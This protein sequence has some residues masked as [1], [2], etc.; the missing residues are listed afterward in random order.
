M[1][2]F[3]LFKKFSS[4]KGEGIS[5]VKLGFKKKRIRKINQN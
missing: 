5:E 3:V 1:C 2:Y 4:R